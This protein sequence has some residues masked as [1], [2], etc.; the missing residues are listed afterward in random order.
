MYQFSF[1]EEGHVKFALALPL[2]FVIVG[3]YD[4]KYVQ[5]VLS[6]AFVRFAFPQFHLQENRSC[7]QP[8]DISRIILSM[9]LSCVHDSF[10]VA[11]ELRQRA[12]I[13]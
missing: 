11:S 10:G 1:A 12:G 6:I 4:C 8:F 9:M 3:G 7:F 13:Q 5:K 2:S